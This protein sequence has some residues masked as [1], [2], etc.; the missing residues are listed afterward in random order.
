MPSNKRLKTMNAIHRLVQGITRGKVG[1]SIGKMPVLEL[2]TKGRKSGLPHKVMLT[3]PLQEN[4]A[5]VIVASR[6]GDDFHP[7]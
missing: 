1:W 3:S 7:A 6:G 2:T 5:I 4:N